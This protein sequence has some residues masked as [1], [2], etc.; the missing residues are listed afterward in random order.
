MY[1]APHASLF[2]D[3]QQYLFHVSG[4]ENPLDLFDHQTMELTPHEMI[5]YLHAFMSV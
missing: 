1:L 2:L 4:D 5:S 3:H